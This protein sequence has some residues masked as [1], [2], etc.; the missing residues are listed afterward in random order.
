MTHS[1]V[2]CLQERNVART[3][4]THGQ[5]Y[6]LRSWPKPGEKQGQQSDK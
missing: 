4:M 2:V 3:L 1:K 6:L 5:G